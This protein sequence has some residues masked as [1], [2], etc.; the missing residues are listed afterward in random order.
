MPE[1]LLIFRMFLILSDTNGMKGGFQH[2]GEGLVYCEYNR[3]L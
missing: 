1:G 2:G 3:L